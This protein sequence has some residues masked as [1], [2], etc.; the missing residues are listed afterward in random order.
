MLN[1]IG[2]LKINT[3]LNNFVFSIQQVIF[4]LLL[5]CIYIYI[6]IQNVHWNFWNLTPEFSDKIL[7]SQ[8]IY[9]TLV[10]RIYPLL[11]YYLS[12]IANFWHEEWTFLRR[13]FQSCLSQSLEKQIYSVKM[14]C[15]PKPVSSDLRQFSTP[16]Y[17]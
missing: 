7:W 16:Q 12:D 8:S 5:W 1:W 15:I 11:G 4:R 17:Y 13:K 9:L 10:V 14:L 6:Y 2:K 3:N